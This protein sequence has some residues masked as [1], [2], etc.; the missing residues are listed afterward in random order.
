MSH[1]LGA[2]QHADQI[3]FLE[4]GRIVERGNHD[5]LV[6][7]GGRYAALYKLQ[8]HEDNDNFWDDPEMKG[9]AE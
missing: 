4:S 1:R 3:L 7:A 8:T 6:A 5:E 9:A 2:L